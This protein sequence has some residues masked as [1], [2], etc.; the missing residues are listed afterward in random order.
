MSFKE[1]TLKSGDH[2]TLRLS[3]NGCLVLG[4]YDGVDAATIHITEEETSNL[5]QDL[6][7]C[8]NEIKKE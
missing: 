8:L 1:H 4:I 7:D 2:Y 3:Y 5:I 6:Q